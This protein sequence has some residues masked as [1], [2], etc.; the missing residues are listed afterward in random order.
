M[1]Q[2]AQL[3]DVSGLRGGASARHRVSLVEGLL[4]EQD[5]RAC[6]VLTLRWL[7]RHAS[8]ERSLCAVVDGEGNHLVVL[9]GT[10]IPFSE[11]EGF[12]LDLGERTHPLV[13]ALLG[14]EPVAF[15]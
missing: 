4:A 1:S 5:G 7:E 8:V 3:S 11:A 12:R 13:L 6:A 15:H 10:G 14:A 9:S 2:P